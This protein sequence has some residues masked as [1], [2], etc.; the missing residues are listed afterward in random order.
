MVSHLFFFL[1]KTVTSKT[2]RN[3]CLRQCWPQCY[4]VNKKFKLQDLGS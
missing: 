4:L 2:I 3:P 1:F